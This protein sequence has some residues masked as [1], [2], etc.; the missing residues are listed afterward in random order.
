MNEQIMKEVNEFKY[1][2]SILCK[3]GS[4]EG[5]LRERALQERKVV[6]STGRMMRERTVS[7]EVKKALRDG[8]IFP[9][10]TYASETWT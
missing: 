5:E 4:M 6:G 7:T 8:I 2:G 9:I 10:V 1:L 3:Y